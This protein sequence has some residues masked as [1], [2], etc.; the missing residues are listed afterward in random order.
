M[1]Q[2]GV[3]KA[4]PVEIDV[5]FAFEIREGRFTR[6][7]I[8]ADKNEALAAAREWTREPGQGGVG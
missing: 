5:V 1:S 4:V 8:Y 3:R 6:F 7:H 2:P